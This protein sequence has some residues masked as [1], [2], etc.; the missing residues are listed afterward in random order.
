MFLGQ[1]R[2]KH[3][4]VLPKAHKRQEVWLRAETSFLPSSCLCLTVTS[5]DIY[6]TYT[7][8]RE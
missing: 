4:D 6:C 5:K 7:R 2:G 1:K 3:F 8:Q